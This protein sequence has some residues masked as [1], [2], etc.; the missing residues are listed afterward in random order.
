MTLIPT[1]LRF[2]LNL[3]GHSSRIHRARETHFDPWPVVKFFSP[4]GAA[5]W[6]ASEIDG[7]GDTLFGLADLGFGCP[8]LGCF[9][10]AEIAAVRL[11]FGLGIERDLHFD[12]LAPLSLWTD[13][14]RR[15]GSIQLAEKALLRRKLDQLLPDPPTGPEREARGE[16]S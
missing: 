3:N 4:V 15:L 16:G 14:A 10:L 2:A 5:T 12:P 11:P 1:D 9:S 6:L 13:A 7:D 8:E